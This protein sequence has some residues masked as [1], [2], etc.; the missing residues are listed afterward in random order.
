MSSSPLRKAA[1]RTLDSNDG[2][3]FLKK[4]STREILEPSSGLQFPR[5]SPIGDQRHQLHCS[6]QQ[7]PPHQIQ[8]FRTAGHPINIGVP[9]EQGR[10]ETINRHSSSSLIPTSQGQLHVRGRGYCQDKSTH[11]ATMK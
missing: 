5:I 6:Q 1:K 2:L 4:I 9:D 10:H 3:T 8:W 11:T 7:R